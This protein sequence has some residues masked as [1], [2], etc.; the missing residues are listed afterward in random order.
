M[1][2]IIVRTVSKCLWLE[3]LLLRALPDD[4]DEEYGDGK[5]LNKLP[6]PEAGFDQNGLLPFF[7]EYSK[8]KSMKRSPS[9]FLWNRS[10]T[11]SKCKSVQK[12]KKIAVAGLPALH[13]CLPIFFQK[14]RGTSNAEYLLIVFTKRDVRSAQIR[15][16]QS[17]SEMMFLV[18]SQS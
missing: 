11:D 16:E 5:R 17:F 15:Y 1:P 18:R 13:V 14:G 3:L 2:S 7:S 10:R 6:T 9:F 12:W 4:L 8:S